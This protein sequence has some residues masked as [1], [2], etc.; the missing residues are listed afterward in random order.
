[1][2][3]KAGTNVGFCVFFVVLVVPV[4]A[5]KSCFDKIRGNQVGGWS[6]VK[7][8][9]DDV[10][11]QRIT[12]L[13]NRYMQRYATYEHEKIEAYQKVILIVIVKSKCLKR[14]CKVNMR[15]FVVRGTVT[16][17]VSY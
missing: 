10:V 1:M 3:Q 6:A 4:L 16:V 11:V 8:P 7:N 15:V 12:K 13:Y 17:T 2:A 9:V 5:Q 14:Y